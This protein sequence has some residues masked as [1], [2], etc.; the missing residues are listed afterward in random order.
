MS[1]SLFHQAKVGNPVVSTPRRGT[2]DDVLTLFCSLHRL[3]VCL[4]ASIA[5]EFRLWSG[6]NME[7]EV[8]FSSEDLL[9]LKKEFGAR[10]LVTA[11]SATDPGR[12]NSATCR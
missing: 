8:V 5:N 11:F 10:L 3:K 4:M 12:T 9:S 2:H 1:V 6:K 7:L